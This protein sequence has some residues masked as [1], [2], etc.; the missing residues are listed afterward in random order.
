MH[1]SCIN[2]VQARLEAASLLA[3]LSTV[4]IVYHHPLILAAL[5]LL[6]EL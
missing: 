6:S 5:M 3:M 4:E 1:T 2:L